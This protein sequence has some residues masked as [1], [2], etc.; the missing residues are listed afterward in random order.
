M[1]SP[2]RGGGDR[3][4]PSSVYVITG[5]I[6]LLLDIPS[7]L[8]SRINV[9]SASGG[10]RQREPNSRPCHR[11]ATS[12]KATSG[13]YAPFHVIICHPGSLRSTGGNL[14]LFFVSVSAL[15]VSVSGG[16]T[17]RRGL[18]SVCCLC[19]R[20]CCLC[21]RGFASQSL[22]HRTTRSTPFSSQ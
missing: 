4:I 6:I 7:S 16:D 15:V 21:L 22:S 19:L 10:R 14:P 11:P 2:P 8:R 9:V 3:E 12:G 17:P 5:I 1:L 18:V 20:S 13:A